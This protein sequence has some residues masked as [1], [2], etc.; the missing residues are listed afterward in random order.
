MTTVQVTPDAL[1]VRLGPWEKVLGLLGD[2]RVPCSAVSDVEVVADG[3]GAP[4]G[5]RAPG[6][7]VPGRIKLGT[8]RRRGS[9][10]YVAV[11]AGEPALRVTLTGQ[12][13]ESLLLGTPDANDLAGK[14]RGTDR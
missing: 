1:E 11:R 5:M 6:L 12:R 4:T 3:L 14:L 9:K 10:Q 2:L 7:A 8:W 13:Y